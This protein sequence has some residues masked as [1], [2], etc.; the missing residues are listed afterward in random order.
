MSGNPQNRGQENGRP[1]WIRAIDLF[2]V[3]VGLTQNYSNFDVRLD[4]HLLFGARAGLSRGQGLA[5]AFDGEMPAAN[6]RPA[7]FFQSDLYVQHSIFLDEDID[8]IDPCQTSPEV[9]V[10]QLPLRTGI[11]EIDTGSQLL[12][13]E[14][15]CVDVARRDPLWWKAWRELFL[16][17]ELMGWKLRHIRFH[18]RLAF[19][20]SC[21][22]GIGE[23]EAHA[24][25]LLSGRYS[26]AA[27]GRRR[28]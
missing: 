4:L 13:N 17:I 7:E 18:R 16:G 25:S 15:V 24:V 3:K 6:F 26:N 8:F 9:V 14:V 20:E 19:P 12:M 2:R 27:G 23:V 10:K 11:T 28:R 21:N 1:E 22:P 5:G